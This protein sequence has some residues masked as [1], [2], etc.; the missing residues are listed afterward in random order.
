MPPENDNFILD[1]FER[2]I[3]LT[4]EQREI[5]NHVVI[6]MD[7]M[8]ITLRETNTKLV[9][10]IDS[11]S[12]NIPEQLKELINSYGNNTQKCINEL[13]NKL[14]EIQEDNLGGFVESGK[15]IDKMKNRINLLYAMFVIIVVQLVAI[16]M[17]IFI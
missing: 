12:H 8:I 3:K 15:E 4:T 10:V 7:D 17:K 16:L 14:K 6:R 13:G 9:Q 11:M 2:I 1:T 5:L